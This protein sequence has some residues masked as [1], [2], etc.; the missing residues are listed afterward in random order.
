ASSITTAV[1]SVTA[2]SLPATT[3]QLTAYE[4]ALAT[5]LGA[6]TVA[7]P[8]TAAD[9]TTYAT[10]K[11]AALS[12]ASAATATAK[13]AAASAAGTNT[14]ALDTSK[15]TQYVGTSAKTVDIKSLDQDG[16]ESGV[17]DSSSFTNTGELIAHF[18][19]GRTRTLA[20]LPV[21]SFVSADQLDPISGTLFRYNQRAG[22]VTVDPIYK[23]GSG[24]Q[25]VSSSLETS[26]VDLADEFTKM[27]ITQK[28]YSMNSKVFTTADEMTQTA[29][30]LYR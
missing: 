8:A 22:A 4:T 7:A 27:I 9:L 17:M 11:A 15:F 5:A 13:A 3:G 30:D 14:V 19:N 10:D 16:Y 18:S 21:A 20:I 6:I 25:I 29:R 1:A 26:N 12:T 24:A 28:A 2:P 23:Q